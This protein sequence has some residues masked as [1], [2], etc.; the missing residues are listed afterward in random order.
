MKKIISFVLS[1]LMLFNM[2]ISSVQAVSPDATAA[3]SQVSALPGDKVAV[4][5]N[6]VCSDGIKTLSFIDFTF[7]KTVLTIV[8]SECAWLAEGKIKDIDF[9]NNASIITFADNTAFNGDIF[10]LVFEVSEDAELGS[11][12]ISCDVIGTK[13]IDKVET[14][15]D[16]SI[17]EGK[18]VV[19]DSTAQLADFEYELNNDGIIITAYIGNKSE[20]VIG[21]SYEIDGTEYDVVEIAMEAFLGQEA[22]TGV[23]IPETVKKIG[24]A[25]FY[26]CTS[27]TEVTVLSKDVVID[28]VALGYYYVSRK[29]HIV[30][31][32]TIYGYEGSTAETYAAENEGVSFVALEEEE[33]ECTHKGGTANCV[34]KAVC[35]LCGEYYGDVDSNNHKTVVIDEAVAPDCENTGLTEGSHCSSCDTVI[36][37]QETVDKLGHD[38]TVFV[39]TVDYT[40]DK[41]G[42]DVYKCSRCDATENKNFTDAACRP[43]ADYTVIEKASCDKAG[44]K[45]ILC[46]E[47]KEEIETETIA[48][49]EHSIVDTTVA[50]KATCLTE[51]V[52]NQKCVCAASDEYEACTYTTT[53]SIPVDGSNHE[54]TANVVKNAKDATCY[55]E[56]YTGDT[57]WSCCDVLYANG[58][59]TDKIAHTP[60]EAVRENEVAATCYKAGSYD[61]VVYCSVAECKSELSR[62]PKTIE[63]ISHTSAEAVRE[64]EK[65]ATCYAEGSYDAVV[66][67][68]VAECKA[69]LSR[70]NETIEKTAHTPAEAVRE[71]ENPASCD[72]DGSYEEVVY[73]SVAECKAEISRETKKIPP[74]DEHNYATEVE[75]SRVPSTCKTA[76]KVTMK[77]GC[78]AT[79][80]VALEIDATNH[81]KVVTDAAVA[82][83]CEN[84]GLTE[85]SH[86]SACDTVIIAQQT[87]DKLGHTYTIF[88]ETVPY[89]CTEQGYD[90]YKC[91]RC[92]ATEK[93]NFTDAACRPEADY[94]VIEKA[95]C[96]KAGY[97]AILCSE[98]DKELETETIA[99]REHNIVDTTVVTKAT[100]ITEGVMNQKC[101]CA[102]SDEYEACTYTTTRSIPVDVQNHKSADTR[103][104]NI[105]V[106]TCTE[107]GYTGDECYVCCGAVKVAGTK[108]EKVDHTEEIIP[109]VEANCIKTGLTEGKKCSVCSEILIAQKEI[110]K[111]AHIEERI[112]AIEPDC[113]NEGLTEGIKCLLCGEILV[114][115]ETIDALGHSYS[116][117]SVEYDAEG[118]GTVIYRC[119]VCSE[120]KTEEVTFDINSAFD[121]IDKAEEKLADENLSDAQKEDIEEAKAQ[122]EAFIEQYVVYDEEG[123]IVENNIPFED[124]EVMTEYH[125]L[126][127]ELE[128]AVYGN[129]HLEVEKTW[130]EIIVE[131]IEIIIMILDLVYKLVMYIKA[132]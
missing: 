114:E 29:E 129:N 32:F 94:T 118:N 43:E 44:Y 108:T 106:A 78:G 125:K 55:A 120:E 56:G 65:A 66:Y 96:D 119:A 34:D 52:M 4:Y 112:P 126:L 97:K 93:K 73:C 84:T 91:L 77:C 1:V 16:I 58:E 128:N 22:I 31:G 5:I 87:V 49:R 70:K 47:C 59:A 45:A 60:A 69:E 46:S 8:E 71:N 19:V 103:I 109:A 86:C 67:C 83:D 79:K 14:E 12:P 90:V 42:Y 33:E 30:E 102:A 64:N 68:S 99:K 7:D 21:E 113:V 107:E 62:T 116:V 27:L 40:C 115:Q 85:G 81:E 41:D 121:L 24:E 10:K 88:V 98:C 17:T 131:L 57:Y 18:I 23:T 37:E 123:N 75:G 72:E 20:V 105:K 101:D 54:G 11:I 6:F 9:E 89:T 28:A 50:T 132:N 39:E 111:T 13:M 124:N 100:C 122:L 48:K 76:G 130:G 3:I 38:F 95:S 104:K 80:D 110:E 117:A 2:G 53:R 35:D 74:T 15:I 92:D 61:E 25:A 82:P 51:G 63:K 36:V 127:L 26:D